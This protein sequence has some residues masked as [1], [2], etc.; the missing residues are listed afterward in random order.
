VLEIN[1]WS[2]HGQRFFAAYLIFAG[3]NAVFSLIGG[4]PGAAAIAKTA[5][6][7]RK[8]INLLGWKKI[9]IDMEHIAYLYMDGGAGLAQSAAAGGSKTVFPTGMTEKQ[10]ENAIRQAYRYGNKISTQGERVKVQ[11]EYG[12]MRIEMWVNT[13][14][15][16]IESAYPVGVP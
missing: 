8:A 7:L 5:G 6:L 12:G 11:G 2:G 3:E 10:V 1:F 16:K 14:E 4:T 13:A 15:R 9:A